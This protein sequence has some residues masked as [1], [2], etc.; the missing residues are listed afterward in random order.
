[1]P[2]AV[3]KCSQFLT[4]SIMTALPNVKWMVVP[5][6][7]SCPKTSRPASLKTNA[8]FSGKSQDWGLPL[9]AGGDPV[10]GGFNLERIRIGPSVALAVVIT[11]AER[12]H[13]L[14]NW[15]AARG[16]ENRRTFGLPND[17]VSGLADW[18]HCKS[19]SPR[20]NR[21]G[22]STTATYNAAVRTRMVVRLARSTVRGRDASARW[23]ARSVGDAPARGG[24]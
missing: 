2:A 19:F 8:V 12:R 17:I 21:T 22:T 24:M 10:D 16:L 20:R 4:K 1:M 13:R 18:C 15:S 23:P 3:T 14:L 6:G 11:S 5:S 9:A 7:S